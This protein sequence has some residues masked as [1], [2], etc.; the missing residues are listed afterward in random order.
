LESEGASI[1]DFDFN[2]INEYFVGFERQ[3][4]G[5]SEA[6][7]RA[8]SFIDNLKAEAHIA[9]LGCGTG[10]QTMTLAQNA[11]GI[12]TGLDL[13]PGSIAKLNLTAKKLG[14]DDR[15]KG[16]VGSMEDLPFAKEEFDLIWS[17][18]AIGNIG[19]AKGLDHWR[20]FL[21]KGGYIALTYESW[22][23]EERPS[24]IE[25]FWL[26]AVPEMTTI[27]QNITSAQKAGYSL[28]AAFTLAETCWTDNYFSPQKAAQEEFLKRHPHNPTV[29]AFIANMRRE[30]ELYDKYKEYY[31]YIFYI[32]K[33]L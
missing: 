24:E 1:H 20:Q 30:A 28:V 14:L 32:V 7:I 18:G 26:D 31:G 16:I 2:L 33:K 9:D 5:S 3:G 12:I 27:G 4:P 29:K 19:F 25:K 21:K 23:T 17:E 22:L 6:T 15:V 10:G 11:P 13:F 8:L